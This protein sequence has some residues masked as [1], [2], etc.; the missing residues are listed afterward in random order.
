MSNR[1]WTPEQ[2]EIVIELFYRGIDAKTVV[3]KLPMKN[4]IMIRGRWH[5]LRKRSKIT[6]RM[7]DIRVDLIKKAID[8][9]GDDFLKVAAELEFP[10]SESNYSTTRLSKLGLSKKPSTSG[11]RS[12]LDIVKPKEIVIKPKLY[13]NCELCKNEACFLDTVN[14]MPCKAVSRGFPGNDEY[15]NCLKFELCKRQ[16]ED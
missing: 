11:G 7:I 8:K 14:H 16:K 3:S 13:N 4:E 9:V 15:G 12:H 5:T 6:G 10:I 1:M 2:D